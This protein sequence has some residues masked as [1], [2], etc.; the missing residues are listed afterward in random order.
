MTGENT[1]LKIPAVLLISNTSDVLRRKNYVRGSYGNKK[2]YFV[3]FD[4]NALT[5]SNEATCNFR[6][7][8]HFFFQRLGQPRK[9]CESY[10]IRKPFKG[11]GIVIC[12]LRAQSGVLSEKR[13]NA[14]LCYRVA[15]NS[16]ESGN[17]L[18]ALNTRE[19]FFVKIPFLFWIN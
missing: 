3:I 8:S 7:W 4:C 18:C 1:S 2:R 5:R 6:V 19:L 14:S 15:R 11:F 16:L 9:L 12:V 10:F 17:T 13:K